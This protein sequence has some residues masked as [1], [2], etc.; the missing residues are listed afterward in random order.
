MHRASGIHVLK[1]LLCTQRLGVRAIEVLAARQR[2]FQSELQ[3]AKA[4]GWQVNVVL[5]M[6]SLSLMGWVV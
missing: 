5:K 2:E 3:Q 6:A 1:A 4:L